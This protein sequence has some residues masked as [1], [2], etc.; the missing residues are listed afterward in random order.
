[1][2]M[3]N[4]D[5]ARDVVFASR[6]VTRVVRSAPGVYEVELTQPA[7]ELAPDATVTPDGC[8]TVTPGRPGRWT[9]RTYDLPDVPSD[10][11]VIVHWYPARTDRCR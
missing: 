3:L 9:V 5:G 8:A 11:R 7:G 2:P 4:Y 10:K 6:G 1:M